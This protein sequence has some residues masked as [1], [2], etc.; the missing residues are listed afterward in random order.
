MHEASGKSSAW[1][2]A[3]AKCASRNFCP[4]NA[5][6]DSDSLAHL[7]SPNPPPIPRLPISW[8][9]CPLS[10]RCLSLCQWHALPFQTQDL[11]TSAALTASSLLI[12]ILWLQLQQPAQFFRLSSDFSNLAMPAPHDKLSSSECHITAS[13][14]GRCIHLRSGCH[15]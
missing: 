12:L 10:S 14:S 6:W 4:T 5:T 11:L 13:M 9:F 7:G 15:Q 8:A 3:L 1:L 2:L